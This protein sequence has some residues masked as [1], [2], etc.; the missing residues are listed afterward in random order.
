MD[1]EPRLGKRVAIVGSIGAGKS[2]LARPLGNQLNRD[3]VELDE[4]WWNPGDYQ[5]TAATAKS[6]TMVRERWCQLNRD[7]T[8]ADSWIIDGSLDLLAMRLARADTVVFVDLPRRICLPRVTKRWCSSLRKNHSD[9]S[10][11]VGWLWILVRWV[12]KYPGKRQWI[13]S[14]IA[15]HAAAAEL[16]RLRNRRQIRAFLQEPGLQRTSAD[17]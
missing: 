6:K 7:L 15:E 16:I 14:Q 13:L 11:A 9:L 17:R 3:V 4:L 8:G 1:E 10:G 12:W 2:T 5:R